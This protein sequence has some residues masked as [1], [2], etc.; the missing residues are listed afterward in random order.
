M[1]D[2][3]G[4][5]GLFSHDFSKD[6]NN[7]LVYS[8]KPKAWIGID[9]GVSG[10]IGIITEDGKSLMVKTPIKNE[11]SYTKVKNRINRVDVIELKKLLS[12]Y[13]KDS[14]VVIERPMVN[15][16]MFKTT[17]SA[18]R[19]LEATLCVLEDLGF[20]YSY[21]DSKQWQREM[22]PSG[23]SGPELKVVSLEI[24]NR[25]FPQITVKHPDRDSILM[26]E[27]LRRSLK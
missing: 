8:T 2:L 13:S 11:Q 26:A 10:S 16:K 21:F 22:L 17:L 27:Y 5:T 12:A 14:Q 15:P 9:N 4:S 1:S 6:I 23:Y 25:L 7:L 3:F 19:A 24:G 20:A 18:M